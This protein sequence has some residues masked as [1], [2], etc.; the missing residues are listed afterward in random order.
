M[1]RASYLR[2]LSS[3]H[4]QALGL[5]QQI[6]RGH[7]SGADLQPMIDKVKGK[8]K[9]ELAPHFI[10]EEETILPE[11]RRLGKHALVEKTL[12]DHRQM[13]QLIADMHE[14]V[15]L[16]QFAETLKAHVRFEERILF[17]ACEDVFGQDAIT[18]LEDKKQLEDI[19]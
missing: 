6:I 17:P 18:T 2:D 12:E 7:E 1:K 15:A 8:F 5:A 9:T 13:R 19:N 3:D 4:H 16:L 14:A 11:L 10:A